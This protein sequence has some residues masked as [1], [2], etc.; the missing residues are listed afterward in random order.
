VIIHYSG[1]YTVKSVFNLQC[2]R[3][4]VVGSWC[5]SGTTLDVVERSNIVERKPTIDYELHRCIV[6]YES[7]IVFN[8]YSQIKFEEM[9]TYSDNFC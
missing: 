3:Y 7:S 1:S 6:L 5:E 2:F 4:W 8:N 9:L